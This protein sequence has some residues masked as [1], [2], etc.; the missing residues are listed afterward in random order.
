MPA[1]A[2]SELCLDA[3]FKIYVSRL[4]P[5][6][7]SL[8]QRPLD[9]VA[10]TQVVWYYN[11]PIGVNTL[12]TFMRRLSEKCF[13]SKTYSNN[14]IRVTGVTLL[15]QLL[16]VQKQVMSVSGHKSVKSMAVYERISGE[17]KCSW[18]VTSQ[19]Y[20]LVYP[21]PSNQHNQFFSNHFLQPWPRLVQLGQHL[22]QAA[23]RSLTLQMWSN[24][25]PSPPRP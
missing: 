13:L 17:D 18:V 8:W 15:H 9:N 25:L 24:R 3:A 22:W 4:N 1:H 7:D 2:R 19:L 23:Q 6:C 20:W 21:L 12:A 11:R 5:I 16:F 14:S 10:S